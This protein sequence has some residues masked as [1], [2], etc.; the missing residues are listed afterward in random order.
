VN[1]TSAKVSIVLPTYNGSRYLRQSIDSC[2]KQTY[3]NIEL[4][5]VDDGSTDGTPAII[6]SYK[7]KRI[8]Y[9]KHKENRG[10]P[11]SL[12]T[13]FTYATGAY[14]TWTSDDNLYAEKAIEIMLSFLK[15]KKL[16][17]VYC[18]FYLFEKDDFQ[19]QQILKLPEP[20]NLYF[21]KQSKVGPCFLYSKKVREVVGDYNPDFVFVEDCD[22]WIRVSRKF[23]MGHLDVP[24]YFYRTHMGSLTSL[25][26]YDQ[27]INWV[28]LRLNHKLIDI[29]QAVDNL[30][31]VFAGKY[32]GYQRISKITKR[33]FFFSKINKVLNVLKNLIYNIYWVYRKI[34]KII[35][36]ALFSKKINKVLQDFKAQ[37]LSLTETKL[38]LR[39]ILMRSEH[40]KKSRSINR[41]KKG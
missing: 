28:L 15:D 24:I 17:F 8:R 2:L 9:I 1:K 36:S 25:R 19:N 32:W 16:E 39:N 20:H 27:K 34:N 26:Y 10:L 37:S 14:L 12:N 31:D 41:T 38:A 35:I 4:I 23:L 33:I 29:D 22:Y 3:K 6:K 13:G 21:E 7:D 5:I 18:D 30:V 11:H 40:I